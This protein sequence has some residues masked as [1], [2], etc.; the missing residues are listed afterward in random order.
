M[1]SQMDRFAQRYPVAAIDIVDDANADMHGPVQR[2]VIVL[3]RLESMGERYVDS[4]P[5]IVFIIYHADDRV[6]RCG[7]LIW[8]KPKASAGS[9][10]PESIRIVLEPGLQCL[11]PVPVASPVVLA[12]V[13]IIHEEGSVHIRQRAFFDQFAHDII[14]SPVHMLKGSVDLG[15]V[16]GE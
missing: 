6:H 3:L 11:V 9:L 10:L 16:R 2:L 4:I 12:I 13:G 8:L 15:I 14:E 1:S 5:S 7:C